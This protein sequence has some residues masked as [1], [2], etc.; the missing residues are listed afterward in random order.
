MRHATKPSA[1]RT[2]KP[3]MPPTTPATVF[4]VEGD[5]PLLAAGEEPLSDGSLVGLLVD[6]VAVDEDTIVDPSTTVVTAMIVV[7]GV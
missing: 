1:A 5:M 6:D 2:M 7:K 4:F 3:P